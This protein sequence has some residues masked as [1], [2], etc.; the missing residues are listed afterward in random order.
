MKKL[1]GLWVLLFSTVIP[2]WCQVDTTVIY[3]TSMPY[4]TLDLRLAKS[5]T[6]FYY[7][8]EDTTFSYRESAPGVKTYTYR[9][10]TSWDSS[11][12]RQGNLREKNGNQDL[13]VMNYRF[14]MPKNYNPSYDPGYPVIIMFHGL[15]ERG[16]CWNNNCYWSTT[17]W[18]P[19]TNSPPAPVTATHNLLNNDHN[20]LHGGQKHLDAVN[21]TGGKLP[22]D[23]TL[24]PTSFPGFVVFPQNLNG[25]GQASKVEDAIRLLRLIIKKYNIDE[26]R[27]YIHGLSNGGGAVFQAIKRAPWLFA[28]ALPMS[29][30][31]D[32]GII[33]D[34]LAQETGKIPLWI[35]QGGQDNNPTPSKTFNTVKRLEEAGSDVRYYLYP[36]LGHGTWNTAY[37]EPDFFTWMLS[38]RKYNP[39]VYYGNPVICNTTGAGV[40][41]S[42]SNGFLSYQWEHDG[43]IIAGANQS[44]YIANEPGT[45]RGRFSRKSNPAESDWQPWSGSIVVTEISPAKPKIDVAGT[46]HLRGPGLISLPAN[47]TVTLTS[48][49]EA[50]LYTWYKNGVP[51]NFPVT[52]IDDT[53][54]TAAFT[55]SG[56]GGNGAYTL[57]TSYS[58]CPSPPSDP[59]YL[60]FANSAPQNIS[61]TAAQVDFKGVPKNS[62]VFLTWNDLAS[63]ET[64]YDVWRKKSGTPDF[65]Y[66]GRS[67]KD[68]IS[69][70]DSPLEPN[71]TY[72]YKLRAVSNTGASNY[73]PSN[74]VAI[75]LQVTTPPDVTPPLAPQE[76]MMT[77]NTLTSVTLNW[78]AALDN[79]GIREYRIEYGGSAITTGTDLTSFTLSGLSANSVFPVVVKAIDHAGQ[80]SAPS[81]Q[82]MASTYVIGLFYKHSTGAWESLDDSAMVASFN[83]PEFT[84]TVTNFSLTPRTQED[85]FNFEFSGYLDI[86]TEGE[87]T[88]RVTSSD[89]SRLI[90]DDQVVIDNDGEHGN[91]T[92]LSD[93]LQLAKGPH[94]LIVPY[95]EYVGVQTLTVQYKR[96]G[97]TTYVAIPDSLLRSGKY[98]APIPPSMPQNL[99]ATAAGM[100]RIDLSWSSGNDVEIYRSASASGAFFIIGR[101]AT[102]AFVDTVGVIPGTTF[103]YKA[104]T[105]S[106][107]G[108]SEFTAIVSATTSADTAP[109]SIPGNLQVSSK[110]HTSIAFTWSPS[111]D[112]AGVTEYEIFANGIFA[113][114]SVITGFAISGLTP[115]TAYSLT[116]KAKDATGNMSAASVALVVTTNPSAIFYSLASGDLNALATWKQN[117][118]G[119]GNSPVSFSEAAQYFVI[120]NR[121]QTGLGGPWDVSLSASKVIVP[122]GVTLTVDYPFTGNLDLEGTA[123]LNLNHTVVPELQKISAASTV[124]FNAC[125]FIP[126]HTYGHVILSGAGIKTFEIDTTSVSGNLTVSDGI[127]LK[128]SS[129]N[130]TLLI[131]NGNM[132]VSGTAGVSGA[133]NRIDLKFTD[134]LSHTLSS[135]S[136]LFFY[137]VTAGQN[138]TVTLN[139]TGSPIR[140]IT[141]SLNGGG[142]KLEN[143][144]ALVAGSNSIHANLGGT[145]NPDNESGAISISGGSVKISSSSG[146]PSNLY[147]NNTQ[148]TLDSLTINLSGSGVATVRNEVKISTGI[149]IK[150][151]QLNANGHVT[152]LSTSLKTASIGEIENEGIVSGT[153]NVQHYLE[154]L[155]ESWRD[156]SAVVTD[157][158]VA[159]W[160]NYFPVTGPFTGSSGGST[161]V[162]MFVS[163]STGLSGYPASGGSNQA[164]LERGKGYRTKISISNPVT[165]QVTG[166]PHQGTIQ[167][168]LQG[169]SGGGTNTGWNLIGNPYASPIEWSADV[170]SWTRSGLSSTI[171]VKK[172]TVVNGQPVGQYVYYNPVLGPGIIPAGTAFWVQ[173]TQATPSLVIAEKAKTAQPHLYPQPDDGVPYL[174]VSLKQGSLSDDAYLVF[175]SAATDHFDN[176]SDGLKRSNEGMFNLSTLAGASSAAVN[177]LSDS[178]CSKTVAL[179]IDQV[180]PGSY[181]LTFAGVQSLTGLG[182]I[183]L[184]DQYTGNSIAVSGNP[185]SFSIT[186]DP[187]TYGTNR[188]SLTFSRHQLNIGNPQVSAEDVCSGDFASVI[189]AS[190]QAGVDY[191]AIDANDQLL[192]DVVQAETETVSLQIPIGNLHQGTNH[193]RVRAG[194]PGCTSQLLTS[195]VDM[196]VTT[197]FEVITVGDVSVC[198][199][200]QVMLQASGVPEGGHYQWMDE[201]DVPIDSVTDGTLLTNPVIS[202][203]IIKVGGVLSNGCQSEWKTIHL[204]ADT[205]EVPVITLYNDTLFVQVEANYLWTRNGT[206]IEGATNPYYVPAGSGIYGVIVSRMGCSKQATPFDYVIDPGC[207]INTTA[208]AVSAEDNCGDEVVM[209]TISDSQSGVI[210]SALNSANE[211]ISLP[212]TGTGGTILLELSAFGLDAGINT[213][214]IKAD[215]PGCIDRVL[216]SVASFRYTPAIPKPLISVQDGMLVT[217]STGEYQWKKNGVIITGATSLAFQP[218]STGNYSVAISIANCSVESDPL[219][220]TVTGIGLIASEFVLNTYP[221]PSKGRELK[222]SVQSPETSPVLIQLIDIT[223]RSVYKKL[224]SVG[225][226]TD[227]VPLIPESGSLLNGVYCVI[228]TQGQTELRRRVVIKN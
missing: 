34:G 67:A 192:S 7:L 73:I 198:H 104:R 161:D 201:N 48:H 54:R 213:I 189:I 80:V 30:I 72:L 60:F 2:V 114:T 179:N 9:D 216:S 88:F 152:L 81:N 105:V 158:K 96:P 50:E 144:S 172:N 52:D 3:N 171:A 135:G 5:A 28:A 146:Q 33:K 142:L 79:T 26:N 58:Y 151:G 70:F 138:A 124:N 180:S 110:T 122:T 93:P 89:G 119:T 49:P 126:S 218:Q 121:T 226:L 94:R 6:R 87:Y 20:L 55:N 74:D 196:V 90:L 139:G 131:V 44:Q 18:N 217:T 45:Y 102:P 57:V 108:A 181:A 143:G 130:E 205:L 85:Y 106:S 210:Y 185:Y 61:L 29:A 224:Y 117:A 168:P 174:R 43:E 32:G 200:D 195:E 42:F 206:V 12:Y 162:S 222:I 41:I 208:P 35:F 92:K 100:K 145:I 170:E 86:L 165:V 188:F 173:A 134:G 177:Y 176:D 64:G 202:E 120:S 38:K 187:S 153:M 47:N 98:V 212:Q 103:Y 10:L 8:Q 69:Y 169:G 91:V 75:N 182:D 63:N 17:G 199:G 136:D 56:S 149:K 137:R 19:N 184:T 204:Y 221:V 191:V 214:V 175:S 163:N 228:A 76:L 84:G 215:L 150:R 123:T 127:T 166:V 53:L 115:S 178:F 109:P 128:G 112:N 203:T 78:K 159:D 107:T 59:V 1:V 220:F 111:T 46:T 186:A 209:I 141:G 183:S 167:F 51:I 156:L 113:G 27:V 37:K 101:S 157:V 16:N 118:N 99:L 21:L 36:H 223:G 154:P 147:F 39:H 140:L 11:P 71:T 133:D 22:E 23:P 82:I 95:F 125:S 164:L 197:P 83:S 65:K 77:G 13:F 24:P 129:A 40:R 225:Q 66:A 207:Q 219:E 68:A 160:Q 211:I 4:G 14:L 25:W 193:I 116:V 148:N 194:F 97:T 132:T 190:A 155:G 15:G 31:N 62:G 227:G